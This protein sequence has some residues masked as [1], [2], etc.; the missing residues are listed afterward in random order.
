MLIQ[1]TTDTLAV[2]SDP[3][4]KKIYQFALFCAVLLLLPAIPLNAATFT[5]NSTVDGVDSNPGDGICATALG[6]CT[7]RAA[8][9]ETNALAGADTIILSKNTYLFAPG[10]ANEDA[11]ASGDLDITGDLTIQGQGPLDTVLVGNG[12]RL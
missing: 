9:Q 8:V 3:W 10:G 4:L 1:K 12:D 2:L 5:V 7:L 6:A 11:A